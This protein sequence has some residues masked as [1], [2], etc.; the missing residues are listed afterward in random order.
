VLR[1][2]SLVSSYRLRAQDRVKKYYD[3]ERV[4]DRYEDLFARMTGR[5][6]VRLNDLTLEDRWARDETRVREMSKK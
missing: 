1:D 3:W 2:G 5:A 4:V 6:P